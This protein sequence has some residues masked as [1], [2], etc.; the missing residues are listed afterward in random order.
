MADAVSAP[1]NRWL[2]GPVPDL[3]LGCGLWYFVAFEIFAFYGA[4]IRLGGG[5]VWAPIL[6]L[7]F[8]VPHHGATLLRVYENR[9]DRRAYTFF[10]VHASLAV[11]AAFAVGVY[12][13]LVG[14]G[15]LTLFLTWSPWHYT[16]QNYGIAVM[17]LRR[18]GIPL[19]PPAKRWL[20][21]TF[22][23]SYALTVL[24]MHHGGAGTSYSATPYDFAGYRF[25]SLA[26]PHARYLFLA[27]GAAYLVSLAVTGLLLRRR[28]S[29][30][31][32]APVACL[33]AS[34]ALWF[35]I[36][37]AVRSWSVRTGLDVL[38]AN[39]QYYFLWIGVAHAVQYLWVTSYYAKASPAW[40][41][42]P[43]YYAKALLAGAAI[44]T[45]PSLVFAPGALGRLPFDAGLAALIA[46]T[47]NLQHFILDGAIWKLRDGRV[48]RILIRSRPQAP[49][50][51]ATAAGNRV[52]RLVWVTGA[53]CAFVIFVHAWESYGVRRALPRG[54]L[55]R[56]ARAA[57]RIAW[58]GRDS[59][60]LRLAVGGAW[61][62][63]GEPERALPELKRAV[64][65]QPSA[66][67]WAAVAAAHAA[68]GSWDL[69]VAAY[70]AALA[71]EPGNAELLHEM[72]VAWLERDEPER[73]RRAIERAVA[74]DPQRSESRRLLRRLERAAGDPDAGGTAPSPAG[75]AH[76]PTQQ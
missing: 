37:V 68:T 34:Q 30:S 33:L 59:P 22:I 46:A 55:D 60:D 26:I 42:Q 56:V 31:D 66:R 38:D 63:R 40:P 35:S 41:G 24:V 54:D 15:I 19:P 72:G 18:R 20:Y 74:L 61:L 3:L 2:Y 76:A 12:S 51:A 65:L 10:A 58:I 44:W 11:W 39:P 7:L 52:R 67:A 69:A 47:V 45:V 6:M 16:G 9:N 62:Q 17:F 25:L 48:A 28:A 5:L 4:D 73:A 27:V 23:L 75:P 53:A 43:R 14:S 13:P 36:P 1:P 32:L 71:L 49:G 70:E 21:A 8:G 64:A 57:E 29:L 50:D